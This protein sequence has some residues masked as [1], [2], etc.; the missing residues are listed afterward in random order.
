MTANMPMPVSNGHN[1]IK[2]FGKGV[3][4]GIILVLPFAVA[5]ALLNAMGI[6][7]PFI[8][9]VGDMGLLGFFVG[10][11]YEVYPVIAQ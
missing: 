10:L 7:Y 3:F 4:V 2:A 9:N 8:T 5:G 1:V 11:G 6:P